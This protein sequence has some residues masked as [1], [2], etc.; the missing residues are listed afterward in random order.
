MIQCSRGVKPYTHI[1][2]RLYIGHIYRIASCTLIWE[3]LQ[4]SMTSKPEVHNIF[5][6]YNAIR[7]D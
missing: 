1:A 4:E 5:G 2:A 7:G 6:I 3:L